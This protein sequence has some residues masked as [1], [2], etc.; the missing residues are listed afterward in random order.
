MLQVK[1]TSKQ[2]EWLKGHEINLA[3]FCLKV[4]DGKIS[5]PVPW[6]E[7]CHASR[8]VSLIPAQV[9]H[10]VL[11]GGYSGVGVFAKCKW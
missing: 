7:N 1:I 3:G 9:L 6:H 5:L 4:P 11:C 2:R 10:A 8:D